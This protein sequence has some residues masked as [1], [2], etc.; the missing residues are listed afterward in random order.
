MAVIDDHSVIHDGIAVWCAT[1]EP[2][3]AMIGGYLSVGEFEASAPAPDVVV[4]ELQ[5]GAAEPYFDGISRLCD[6]G[7][8]VIVFSQHTDSSIVLRCLDRGAVTYLSKSEGREHLTAAIHAAA[9]DQPYLSPTMAKAMTNDESAER[10]SLSARERQVLIS[11]F[12]TESKELVANRLFITVGT[13][14]THLKRIRAKYA[15]AGR[16]AST[17]ASLV[18]RAIQD[19]LIS[20]SEL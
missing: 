5:N 18:A 6:S 12:Q 11:W 16:P 19:G 2:Q 8:R 7:F 1:E 3:M 14:N 13:V 4:F 20:P 9:A 15:A 17:K 10:P